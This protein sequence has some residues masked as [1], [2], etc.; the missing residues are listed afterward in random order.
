MA[1]ATTEAPATSSIAEPKT[2]GGKKG[3]G[4]RRRRGARVAELSASMGPQRM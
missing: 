2:S 3:Q 1:I 4:S